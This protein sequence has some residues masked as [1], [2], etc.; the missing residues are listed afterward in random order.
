VTTTREW[1]AEE[2]GTFTDAELSAGEPAPGSIDPAD[3]VRLNRIHSYLN[4]KPLQ[5]R[6]GHAISDPGSL[7]KRGGNYSEPVTRWSARAVMTIVGAILAEKD[8]EI[9]RL[10]AQVTEFAAQGADPNQGVLFD[11]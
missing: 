3:R 2:I 6:I 1:T 10:Q 4:S 5:E 7:V 11:I 8:A 9:A